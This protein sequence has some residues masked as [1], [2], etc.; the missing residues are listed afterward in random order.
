ML[1]DVR[2]NCAIRS[3]LVV[4]LPMLESQVLQKKVQFGTPEGCWNEDQKW[5]EKSQLNKIRKVTHC[6]MVTTFPL[7]ADVLFRVRPRSLSRA[8][9]TGMDFNGLHC[10]LATL[11]FTR[12]KPSKMDL[13]SSKHP[14]KSSN[15]FCLFLDGPRISSFWVGYLDALADRQADSVAAI[16]ATG[17]W[18]YQQLRL[19]S[20][21]IAAK[22]AQ[23][24]V[25][26]GPR[27]VA[28][29]LPRGNVLL[30]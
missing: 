24:G 29:A 22:L 25:A 6:H 11:I 14:T 15:Q 8:P 19:A 4:E 2:T 3:C 27:P 21:R 13:K 10:C 26:A 5:P 9:H 28:L 1:V 18:S 16:D 17:T 23:A 30:G 12:F 20:K 7:E